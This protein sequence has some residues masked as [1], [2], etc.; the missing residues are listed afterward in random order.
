MNDED[1]TEEWPKTG[2]PAHNKSRPRGIHINDDAP[3]GDKYPAYIPDPACMECGGEGWTYTQYTRYDR[4][5]EPEYVDVEKEPCDCIF[6]YMGV[7][8][9]T[10]CAACG[11][12]GE[13]EE[14][15]IK[16]GERIVQYYSC[17]CLRYIPLGKNK[18]GGGDE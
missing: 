6:E 4:D 11:G 9:N 17:L 2:T 1:Y 12:T 15:L 13:V 18:K 14:V 8:A 10:T 3:I 5:G 7:I 16:D